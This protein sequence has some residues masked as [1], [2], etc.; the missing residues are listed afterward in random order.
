MVQVALISIR[1]ISAILVEDAITMGK[2]GSLGQILSFFV[3]NNHL[4]SSELPEVY[5]N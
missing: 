4:S 5:S 2:L 1:Y 3:I